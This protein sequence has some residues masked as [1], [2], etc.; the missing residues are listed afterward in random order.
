MRPTGPGWGMA[1]STGGAS[2]ARVSCTSHY[3]RQRLAPIPAPTHALRDDGPG[4]QT[5][6]QRFAG[7]AAEVDVG[8]RSVREGLR[9]LAGQ[10]R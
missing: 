4:D 10:G 9:W 5:I 6:R 3:Q 7:T 1:A 8:A 2:G